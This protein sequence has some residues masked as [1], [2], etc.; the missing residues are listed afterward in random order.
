M[1]RQGWFYG[2]FVGTAIALI[3]FPSHPAKAENSEVSARRIAERTNFTN[4]EIIDGFVKLAFR[5][6]LQFDRQIE[7]LRKFDEP[8]RVFVDDHGQADRAAVIRAVVADIGAHVAHLDIATVE[9][10]RVANVVVMLVPERAFQ[11][12]I[13]ARYGRARAK[14]I[15][16]SLNPQCLSGIAKDPQYRIRRAEVLLPG[17]VD[18]FRFYDCAY[19]ELLQALGPINDDAS[20]PWTMFN[21]NVQMGFFD[22]YDQYLLNI[23]YD[24]RVRPGMTKE[25]FG[26]VASDVLSTVRTWVASANPPQATRTH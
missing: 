26:R 12:T 11:R 7:R 14:E 16:H 2:C 19:E 4:D 23:L 20:V 25:D 17:D 15:A 3:A 24:P 9:D 10:R 13:R 8:V 21:D 18:E 6:E 22:L 1:V 5:P